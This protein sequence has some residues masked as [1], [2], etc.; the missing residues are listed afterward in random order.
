MSTLILIA[1]TLWMLHGIWR[2]FR[3]WQWEKRR[4]VLDNLAYLN[5]LEKLK[6][7]ALSEMR[8][9]VKKTGR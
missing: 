9:E 3:N 2:E 8:T 1:A 7:D 5:L 6:E 4:V